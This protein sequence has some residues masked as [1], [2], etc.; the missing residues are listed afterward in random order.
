[1]RLDKEDKKRIND[2]ASNVSKILP[3]KVKIK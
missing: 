1:M 2:L 3:G